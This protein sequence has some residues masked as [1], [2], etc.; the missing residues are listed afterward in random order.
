MSYSS[1]FFYSRGGA[2]DSTPVIYHI[3]EEM[4]GKIK[5]LKANRS[6]ESGYY[7]VMLQ[8]TTCENSINSVYYLL[9]FSGNDN[10]HLKSGELNDIFPAMQF[11]SMIGQVKPDF[12]KKY[13]IKDY[14]IGLLR[15]LYLEWDDEDDNEC[16]SMAFKRPFGNSHVMGDV[17]EEMIKFGDAGA[18]QRYND[19]VD[20]Y[21]EEEKVLTE[22]VDILEKFF[23]EGFELRLRSFEQ[24]LFSGFS[25]RSEAREL[26]AENWS[27]D[28][29]YRLHS[30][31]YEWKPATS[32]IR[33][34]KIKEILN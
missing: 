20:D 22:F 26:A 23:Q 24:M 14:H 32:F 3:T 15:E 7:D 31:M 30:Y 2:K 13:N 5:S 33:E 16:I 17:R 9:Q 34:E 25:G 21:T 19:E 6:N 28:N 18:T 1:E 8:W 12:I 27:F 4:I 10:K 11:I 29:K